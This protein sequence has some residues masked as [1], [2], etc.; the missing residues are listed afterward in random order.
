[1]WI[2]IDT[3]TKQQVGKTYQDAKQARRQRDRLDMAYGAVR[4]VVKPLENAAQRL[5][6]LYG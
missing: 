3:K 2:I 5:A 1:M 4:Y 6:R